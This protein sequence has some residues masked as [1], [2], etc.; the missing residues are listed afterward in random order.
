MSVVDERGA[1]DRPMS[2]FDHATRLHELNPDAPLPHGGRPYPDD[3]LQTKE[4]KGRL[5]APERVAAVRSALEVFVRDTAASV[6][7]LH[8]DLARLYVYEGTAESIVG[9]LAATDP[10]RLRSTGVWLVRNATDRLPAMVG[11]AM[12][13]TA[14]RSDDIPLITTIGLLDYFGPTA[15]KALAALPDGIPHLI[16]LAERCGRPTRTAV[17]RVLAT[18]ADPLA[19]AWL[20]RNVVVD[21]QMSASLARQVA[22]AISLADLLEADTVDDDVL[23]QAADLVLAMVTPNDYR[24]QVV[25][26]RD[27]DRVCDALARHLTAAPASMHRYAMLVSLIAEL[28]SGHTACLGWHPGQRERILARLRAATGRGDWREHVDA[29]LRSADPLTRRRAAWARDDVASDTATGDA[30]SPAAGTSTVR[31]LRIEVAVPDPLKPGEPQTRILVDDQP[32]V[33]AAFDKGPPHAPEALLERG[34]L[35]AADQPH[36]VRL[37]EASCTEGCCGGLYVTIVLDGDTV[38]WRDWRGHTSA[39]PPSEL[40]FAAHRYEAELIRA[41]TIAVGNGRPAPSPG[42]CAPGWPLD[43]TC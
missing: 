23:D 9:K 26:Y 30:G 15:V 3:R 20:R 14:G 37:A 32:V 42:S 18:R 13:I 22:E 36:E 38:V 7:T 10:D 2:L 43:P 25:R 34:Q 16:W 17:I 31:R 33:A 19:V 28:H 21:E 24:A 35:R 8:D 40:R 39:A 6:Q 41:E 1:L 29:A 27:A 12:L 4:R 5:W 11:L